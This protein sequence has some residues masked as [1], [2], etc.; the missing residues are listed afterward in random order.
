M[1]TANLNWSMT[2]QWIRSF[3]GLSLVLSASCGYQFRVEGPGPT[4]GGTTSEAPSAP[5][6]RV[7]IRT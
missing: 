2:T 5:P 4:I 3:V 1:Q 6:P 7:V